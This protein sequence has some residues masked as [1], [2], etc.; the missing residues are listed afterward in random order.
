ML[1]LLGKTAIVTGAASGIGKSVALLFASQGASIIAADIS[2]NVHDTVQQITSSGQQAA[3]VVCDAGS[4][5]SCQAMVDAARTFNGGLHIVVHAAAVS[6]KGNVVNMEEDDWN[7]ILRVNLSSAFFLGKAAVPA[8]ARQGGA[9]VFIASQLGLVGTKDSIAYTSSKGAIVNMTRS[10]S[11]DHAK[12]NIRV[13]CLC[14]GP[15][16]TPFLQRSFQRQADPVAA[17]L[18]SL[19]KIPLGRFGTPEEI[20]Y[21]ALF[22]ASDES[23][24][25]TGAILAADGG[26]TAG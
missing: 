19:E 12:D 16:D 9:I 25:I 20:A 7:H 15:V 10:M 2:E 21:A 24:F 6:A 13:N 1:R 8:L 17:S 14:P 22:L 3:A 4:L 5:E 11:L 26:Y 23:S 18:L